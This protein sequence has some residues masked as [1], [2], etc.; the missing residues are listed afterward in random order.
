M[1][2]YNFQPKTFMLLGIG[3]ADE[4]PLSPGNWLLPAFSTE[5][6]PPDVPDGQ[7]AIFSIDD[8]VWRLEPIPEA[9]PEQTPAIGDSTPAE[10]ADTF[11]AM[12]DQLL[13]KAGLRIAPLQ[14]AV[15]LGDATAEEQA[16]LVAWKQYRVAVNRLDITV[17]QP[18]WPALPA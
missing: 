18:A 11:S 1:Q 15:D 4:D 3:N 10:L 17:N 5:I 14:D 8:Q 16:K 6:A 9:E 7:R 2:I 12:R 13:Q